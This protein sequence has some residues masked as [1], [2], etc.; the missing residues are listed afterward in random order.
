MSL[1]LSLSR[2]PLVV[3]WQNPTERSW[4]DAPLNFPKL[5]FLPDPITLDPS[6]VSKPPGSIMATVSNSASQY[7]GPVGPLRRR[8]GQCSATG[9]KLL[10][11]GGCRAVHY[12][13][14]EHQT[15]H[16]PQHKSACIKIR[17]ARTLVAEED[18]RVRNAE[19]DFMTPANAFETDVGRFWGIWDTRDYM[20]ARF[21]LAGV[22][23]LRLGT[24]D[25]VHEAFDH[26]WDMLKL[27]RSD[28]MG[29]RDIVPAIMLRLDLDQECYDFVKWWA[30]CD[31]DGNYDWGDMTLPY[32]DI[33]GANV[34]E[35]P[36]FLLGNFPALNHIIAVLM[37][38]LKLL[39]DI[40]NLKVTRK[41]LRNRLPLELWELIELGV[42]RSPLSV[43]LQKEPAASLSKTEQTLVGQ[44]RQ[45]GAALVKANHGF[46]F[47]LF[48]PDE[49][50]SAKPEAYSRGF[51]EETALAMQN[52]YAAWWEIE[53][54]LDLLKDARECAARESMDEIADM[55]GSET[56]KLGPGSHR[57]AEELLS[58]VSVNRIWGYLDYA[59]EN[60]SYLGPWSERPSERYTRELAEQMARA[61]AEDEDEIG[62]YGSDEDSEIG[63]DESD[64]D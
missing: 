27:C 8:C 22:H 54:I 14:R 40:R 51:W 9:P 4:I 49:A 30:T 18:H 28:N 60:A 1:P 34:F 12:G 26:L 17:K 61:I 13:N 42:V 16:Y 11:C 15:A 29:L 25:G 6:C 36:G 43:Q 38:K 62:F 41:I 56:F 10:R 53:G 39:V 35:D 31:P 20:R 5:S 21:Q 57:T 33:C 48:E 55:M 59:V 7:K 23:L 45:L 46:M 32:L 19:P 47:D 2:L 44:T 63:F 37:L 3:T 58:D 24:F 50:L 64:D 52:S